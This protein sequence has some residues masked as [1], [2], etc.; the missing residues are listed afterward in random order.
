MSSDARMAIT[1]ST[2]IISINV[3]PLRADFRFGLS[4]IIFVQYVQFI[5]VNMVYQFRDDYHIT[6]LVV[7]SLFTVSATGPAHGTAKSVPRDRKMAR[8]G[9]S[10]RKMSGRKMKTRIRMRQN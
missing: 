3:N 10:G 1:A 2:P 6:P 8:K 9:E 4:F 7:K 5:C